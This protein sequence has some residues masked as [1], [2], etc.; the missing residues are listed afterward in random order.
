MENLNNLDF[1]KVK[2][3]SNDLQAEF[4]RMA[5]IL[6]EQ[7]VI[8]KFDET[9][10]CLADIEFY[11][12]ARWHQDFYSYGKEQQKT[13]GKLWR[14]YSGLDLTF[15]DESQ[16]I[17]GGILI[18]AV[19]EMKNWNL[20]DGCTIAYDELTKGQVEFDEQDFVKSGLS[21]SI[22]KFKDIGDSLRTR[23]RQG[24][25]LEQFE[26]KSSAFDQNSFKVDDFN[27][28][29]GYRSKQYRFRI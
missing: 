27:D 3:Q 13:F 16:N 10:Y 11:I 8:I 19:I 2:Q 26:K 21:Y 29:N 12:L 9:K 4:K 22:S 1:L 5:E 15:G 23:T 6:F 14:H 17:W 28:L 24:L 25:T 20:F 18:R 7:F